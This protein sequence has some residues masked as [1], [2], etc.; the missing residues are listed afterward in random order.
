MHQGEVLRGLRKLKD[1]VKPDTGDVYWKTFEPDTRPGE[2]R[3]QCHTTSVFMWGE[4][5]GIEQLRSAVPDVDRLGYVTVAEVV[6]EKAT[7]QFCHLAADPPPEHHANIM[8]PTSLSALKRQYF[9]SAIAAHA[10]Y[11]PPI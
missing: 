9:A 2:I 7:M 3:D 10:T 8:F 1:Q 11:I 5:G 4:G 6:I